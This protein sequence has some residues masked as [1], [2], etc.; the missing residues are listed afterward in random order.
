MSVSYDASWEEWNH[1]I[2][3]A[4]RT[5]KIE[6]GPDQRDV[7]KGLRKLAQCL[8]Y[9]STHSNS[10]LAWDPFFLEMRRRH[11]SGLDEP[12]GAH[13]EMP[14]AGGY[15]ALNKGGAGYRQEALARRC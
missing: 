10:N 8:A 4:Q 3:P 6:C 15:L 5:V 1:F 14:V 7:C 2:L 9:P 11:G 12:K 13:V